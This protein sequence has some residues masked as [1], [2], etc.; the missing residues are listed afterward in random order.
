MA[1]GSCGAALAPGPIAL[2]HF[3]RFVLDPVMRSSFPNTRAFGVA[4]AGLILVPTVSAQTVAES[5]AMGYSAGWY[6]AVAVIG[7][8]LIAGAVFLWRRGQSS[9]SK[10]ASNYGNRS[11]THN[12][13]GRHYIDSLQ[14]ERELEWLTKP[15][16]K[17]SQTNNNG[18]VTFDRKDRIMSKPLT[19]PAKSTS[20]A[21]PNFDATL[22]QEK[23]RKLQYAR[24]P[25]NSFNELSPA[26]PFQPLQVSND[27]S[28]LSAIEQANEE[29]EEDEAVR[30]LAVRILAA[31]RTRNS[32]EA[33][34]QIALYDLSS[35]LRS[36]AVTILADFDHPS[37]FETILLACA[38]PTREVRAAAARGLFRLSFDRADAWKRIIETG[39]EFRMSHAARAAIEAG[40]VAKSFDRLI[41]DDLKVSYEAFALVALLIRAGQTSE[42][43]EAIRNHRDERVKYALIHVLKTQRDERTIAELATIQLDPACS[44]DVVDR[45][46]QVVEAFEGVPA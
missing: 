30:D 35:N 2:H 22:F 20:P 8:V 39:D 38:D 13:N 23:M 29:F 33:L 5:Q 12:V 42:I 24:L 41:H 6:F 9:S 25:I 17:T 14:A 46:K 32:V 21:E 37:V 45:I 16:K 4:L 34:A 19:V 40:I 27:E 36:K 15:K 43:F 1:I 26:K 11:G 31:F 7:I 28:L 10:R 18:T 3:L 44:T